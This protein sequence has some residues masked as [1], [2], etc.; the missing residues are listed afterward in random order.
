MPAAP[1]LLAC[2]PAVT[3][4]LHAHTLAVFSHDHGADLM[5]QVQVFM[6]EPKSWHCA[7]TRMCGPHP[8]CMLLQSV[9]QFTT[10]VPDICYLDNLKLRVAAEGDSGANWRPQRITLT[11]TGVCVCEKDVCLCACGSLSGGGQTCPN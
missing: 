6:D 10:Q 8:K 5:I 9:T 4:C 2:V 7:H 3:A 1:T 11:N